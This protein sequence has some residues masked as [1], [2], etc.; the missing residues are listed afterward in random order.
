MLLAAFSGTA[1]AGATLAGATFAFTTLTFPTALVLAHF[2]H[3]HGGNQRH[4]GS[5]ANEDVDGAFNARPRTQQGVYQ[6]EVKGT[7]QTPVKGADQDQRKGDCTD[8]TFLHHHIHE[9]KRIKYMY[10]PRV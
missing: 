6:V 2:A 3:A 1:L 7:D 5:Q 9:I 8:A 10:L 4:D